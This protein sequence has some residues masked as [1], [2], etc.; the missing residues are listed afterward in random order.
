MATSGTTTF[1]VT[2]NDI[3]TS[4]LRVIGVLELGAQ[5]DAATI[6]NASLVFNMLIKDWMTDGIKFWTTPEIILPLINGQTVYKIGSDS[7]NDLVTDRPLRLLNAFLRNNSVSPAIDIPMTIIS[8]QEYD[9]LG[10]KYSTGT[11]NSVF[12]KPYTTYSELKVFLTP[13]SNTATNY[14]LHLTIQRPIQDVT[15]ANQ[16]L[17]FPQ[18]WYQALRWGLAS[19]LA[20]EYGLDQKAALITQRAEQYKQRLAAWDVENTSTFFQPDARSMNTK[21]R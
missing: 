11:T 5:P 20:P 17:D 12:L 15:A 8:E 7:S 21:F 4:A 3:I 10:S 19:E 9:L 16:T 14:A 2:R 1:S 6:E 13:D 18:E